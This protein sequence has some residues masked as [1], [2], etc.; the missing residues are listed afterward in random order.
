[1]SMTC[2]CCVFTIG[3]GRCQCTTT[4]RTSGFNY[5]VD[6]QPIYTNDKPWDENGPAAV[7]R[8]SCPLTD[9]YR[10]SCRRSRT[11]SPVMSPWGRTESSHS[12]N[13]VLP[14]SR[15]KLSQGIVRPP[16]VAVVRQR[17][18]RQRQQQ[19]PWRRRRSQCHYV[20]W[21]RCSCASSVPMI[22]KRCARSVK[23]GSP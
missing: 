11:V 6:S 8:W 23:I 4:W 1:M 9:I 5:R 15:M 14:M 7:V 22:W 16:S 10:W 21:V 17:R 20:S 12:T 13:N 3:G 18:L 19:L 2:R